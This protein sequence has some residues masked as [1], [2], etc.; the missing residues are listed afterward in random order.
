MLPEFRFYTG[1]KS[2]QFFEGSGV[3]GRFRFRDLRAIELLSAAYR[4]DR[5]EQPV[6]DDVLFSVEPGRGRP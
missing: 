5:L 4:V 1:T 2:V 6:D 3:V